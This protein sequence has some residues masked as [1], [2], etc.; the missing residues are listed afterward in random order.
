MAVSPEQKEFVYDLFS[1]LGTITSRAMM[2]GM[3]FYANGD[4][5]SIIGPDGKIYIKAKG[6]LADELAA[7]GSEIFSTVI[8]GETK[9]MGYWTLPEDAF[10]DPEL[11]CEWG[12]K[13][14][15]SPDR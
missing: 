3:T 7:A 6:A 4:V 10:D 2:G 11:A 12:R 15:T 14:L 5:F 8:K 1:D 9:S 13:A